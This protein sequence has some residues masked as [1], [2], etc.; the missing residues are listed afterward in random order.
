MHRFAPAIEIAPGAPSADRP[1]AWTADSFRPRRWTIGGTPH[2]RGFNRRPMVCKTVHHT[3]LEV[4]RWY[5]VADRIYFWAPARY[6]RLC[7]RC[8]DGFAIRRDRPEYRAE[9]AGKRCGNRDVCHADDRSLLRCP[10]HFGDCECAL[11][12]ARE[13]GGCAWRLR[14]GR[15]RVRSN[16]HS[17]AVATEGLCAGARR[18]DLACGVATDRVRGAAPGCG[19]ALAPTQAGAVCDWWV[20]APAALDRNP[21]RL[22]FSGLH[23]AP[24]AAADTG[25]RGLDL[26]LSN[27]IESAYFSSS[28]RSRA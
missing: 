12:G 23:R 6:Y 24:A 21:Q 15:I 8:A 1:P 18:L 25:R 16:Y 28:A 4:V 14:G 3:L 2:R 19:L 9:R 11:V 13:C 22:G 5:S 7:G 20:G 26:G 17:A 10:I 27:R